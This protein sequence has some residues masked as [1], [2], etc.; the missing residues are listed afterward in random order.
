[1]TITELR[2]ASDAQ[3]EEPECSASI[4][5]SCL[6]EQQSE[7]A[8]YTEAGECVYSGRTA[9]T[10]SP[11]GTVYG[12]HGGRKYHADKWCKARTSAQS[13]NDWDL[14]GSGWV[15][16][17]RQLNTY[18]VGTY[19][20]AA[21]AAASGKQPC[22]VCVPTEQRRAPAPEAFGHEPT[23]SL[24]GEVCARCTHRVSSWADPETDEWTSHS[25]PVPWPCASAVVLG[26]SIHP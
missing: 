24:H 12:S 6:A 1:M 3:Q 9:A 19:Q 22:L 15:P 23:S 18:G 25:E 10:E 16:G 7:R 14:Y 5:G 20:S 17:C 13:L 21:M 26:L 2:A 11:A 8:C 4:S